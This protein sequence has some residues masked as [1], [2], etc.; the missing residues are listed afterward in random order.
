[1][2]RFRAEAEAVARLQHPN[3]VQI[4]EVGEH[5][6]Q[7]YLSLEFV[8]GGT[9]AQR[10]ARAPQNARTAAAVMETLA[11]AMPPAHQRGIIRRALKPGNVLLAGPA[12]LPLADCTPKITDFGLAKRLDKEL[13][14][15]VTGQVMGTPSYMAPEQAQGKARAIG[16]AADV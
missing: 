3:I 10:L 6:G 12:E 4:Y 1:V 11:R 14:Q 5:D 7:P 15:T 9:L 16:P 8:E 13:G 2:E